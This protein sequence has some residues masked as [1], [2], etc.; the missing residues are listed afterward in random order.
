[1]LKGKCRFFENILFSNLKKVTCVHFDAM[2][3]LEMIN[4]AQ[5]F[6]RSQLAVCK[7]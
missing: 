2:L 1:M 6:I 7:Q 5:I 4:V 3:E